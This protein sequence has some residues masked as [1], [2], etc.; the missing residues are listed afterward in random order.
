MSRRKVGKKGDS[1]A[2]VAKRYKVSAANVAQWNRVG[3]SATFKSTQSVILY[4]PQSQARQGAAPAKGSKAGNKKPAAKSSKPA[5]ASAPK[6]KLK[7]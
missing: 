3:V 4:L 7:K 5:T 2:A 6:K 1:V